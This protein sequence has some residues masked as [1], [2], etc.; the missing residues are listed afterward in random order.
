ME[1]QSLKSSNQNELSDEVCILNFCKLN[2]EAAFTCLVNRY[3]KSIR[4]IIY[5]I[6]RE[7]IEDLED[8]EQEVLLALYKG[9][10]KFSFKSSF[11]TYLY[12]LCRNKAI[13][14]LRKN[15]QNRKVIEQML[16]HPETSDRNTPESLYMSKMNKNSVLNSIFELSEKERS[17][18]IMKDVE[19][20]S[21]SEIADIFHKPVGTI[22]SRLHRARKKVAAKILKEDV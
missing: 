10:P 6:I 7:P 21:I 5:T 4:R 1:L 15:K 12:R 14:Y 22:K 3:S 9:L 13:D 11:S 17:I 2:D 20:L 8:V 19:N 16:N 18:I